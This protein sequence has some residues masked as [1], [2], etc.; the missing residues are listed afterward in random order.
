MNRI[1]IDR[2]GRKQRLTLSISNAQELP[3]ELPLPSPYFACLLAWD[4]C[5]VSADEIGTLAERLLQAAC[6]SDCFCAPGA[7]TILTPRAC[8]PPNAQPAPP[9]PSRGDSDVSDFPQEK[10]RLPRVVHNVILLRIIV[11]G[12]SV[13][14]P[15]EP[16]HLSR[17]ISM[18][19]TGACLPCV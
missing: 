12:G 14:P 17:R 16:F 13:Y 3:T 15:P 2:V 9:F 8:I 19:M 4:A 11:S 10:S 7:G 5:G 1:G 6:A 18:R